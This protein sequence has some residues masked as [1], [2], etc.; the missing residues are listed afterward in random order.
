MLYNRNWDKSQPKPGTWASVIAWLETKDP[1]EEYTY[2]NRDICLAAQYN[3][4]IGRKYDSHKALSSNPFTYFS[5]DRRLERLAR[6]NWTR[7]FGEALSTA[8]GS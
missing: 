1:D 6:G 2:L 5:F 8:R 3:A 7:T 4:S